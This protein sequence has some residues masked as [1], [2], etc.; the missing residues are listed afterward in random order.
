VRF[1]KLVDGTAAGDNG[2]FNCG[3]D[4]VS[5]F[6]DAVWRGIWRYEIHKS[7]YISYYLVFFPR[8]PTTREKNAAR[9]SVCHI[10]RT[11]MT[12]QK[13]DVAQKLA[14]EGK[15]DC[16]IHTGLLT[17]VTASSAT[18]VVRQRFN[19]RF[20]ST[21]IVNADED[22]AI[23]TM[24]SSQRGAS[25]ALSSLLCLSVQIRLVY[26]DMCEHERDTLPFLEIGYLIKPPSI[27]CICATRSTALPLC[28]TPLTSLIRKH[29]LGA[30]AR[31]HTS[32]CDA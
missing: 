7:A 4:V 6:C 12:V 29:I 22:G 16:R 5:Q 8:G 26:I 20:N 9:S 25:S 14:A 21:R 32:L 3:D 15:N 17:T 13:K 19:S 10:A 18:N 2:L 11:G 1:V 28:P 30:P 31:L 24:R 27:T 23:A